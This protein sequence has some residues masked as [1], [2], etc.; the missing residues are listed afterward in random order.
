MKYGLNIKQEAALDPSHYLALIQG[1]SHLYDPIEIE[2]S[3]RITVASQLVNADTPLAY[4]YLKALTLG[5]MQAEIDQDPQ[6]QAAL[7]DAA[8]IQIG[9]PPLPLYIVNELTEAMLQPLPIEP[10]PGVL[11]DG[12]EEPPSEDSA[13]EEPTSEEMLQPVE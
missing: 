1:G 2:G 10:M 7:E 13:L 11:P 8:I 9:Q 5:F 6:Y 12:I 4:S 3:E